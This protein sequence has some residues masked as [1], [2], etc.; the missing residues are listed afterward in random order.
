MA[1]AYALALRPV[2]SVV[3]SPGAQSMANFSTIKR[4]WKACLTAPS[5]HKSFTFVRLTLMPALRN[6]TKK[7]ER[8][9]LHEFL[10]SVLTEFVSN[11]LDVVCVSN[12]IPF[13]RSKWQ[14]NETE[15]LLIAR[16]EQE[17]NRSFFQSYGGVYE[18]KHIPTEV[19][20]LKR[21]DCIDDIAAVAVDLCSQGREYAAMFWTSED[22]RAEDGSMQTRCTAS[23]ALKT[24]EMLQDKDSSLIPTYVS[25]LAALAIDQP[26]LVFDLLNSNEETGVKIT[27]NW[28]TLFDTLRWY[29]RKMSDGYAGETKSSTTHETPSVTS[30]GYYYGVDDY[31]LAG[32]KGATSS[33]ST[34]Q[35]GIVRLEELRETNT[36]IVLSH[37]A[38]IT[39]VASNYARGRTLLAT[40]KLSIEGETTDQEGD[41]VLVVLFSLAIAP[42]SPH[43]RGA[44]FA[45]L[46]ALLRVEGTN[47][48][49]EK[50][51]RDLA[52]KGWDLLELSQVVPVFLLDQYQRKRPDGFSQTMTF[53]PSSLSLVGI[54]LHRR[55][56]PR[57]SVSL[58]FLF[59]R[60]AAEN[61]MRGFLRIPSMGY[62][63]K[64]NTLRVVLVVI[65]LRR[66]YCNCL[67][68]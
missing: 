7:D 50:L 24:L 64:W 35:P 3:A 28:K 5:D 13:S 45:T 52:R 1:A 15:R 27:M 42:L 32:N 18:E 39:K 22:F 65:P 23:R 60:Q 67:R 43:V 8:C 17:R 20:I 36:A 14:D 21:P 49:E 9:D 16:E 41:S 46:A 56:S 61:R 68:H 33:A 29:V 38:V 31:N 19:D 4:T 55:I 51:I 30:N 59:Y 34:V 58:V 44:V 54:D 40:M 62:C 6:T 2:S 26:S 11:Y 48:E 12:A 47:A 37:L 53:P 25:F 63:L 57:F 66:V 10:L